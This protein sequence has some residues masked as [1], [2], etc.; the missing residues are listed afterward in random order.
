VSAVAST[1][2]TACIDVCV[3]F[4]GMGWLTLDDVPAQTGGSSRRMYSY[5]SG[6]ENDDDDDVDEVGR[7][8]RRQR[9]DWRTPGRH[10]A[11][12][13]D[14]DG[15]SS[16]SWVRSGSGSES[17]TGLDGDAARTNDMIGRRV[18]DSAFGVYSRIN[19][20]GLPEQLSS[21]SSLLSSQSLTVFSRSYCPQ[22]DR[23]W[24]S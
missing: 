20:S 8:Q 18:V 3:E 23:L 14:E 2:L 6:S 10:G 1:L 5:L 13:D 16:P 19:D 9:G 21:L 4:V 7:G 17:D 12:D 22:C 11:Q 24:A 15:L